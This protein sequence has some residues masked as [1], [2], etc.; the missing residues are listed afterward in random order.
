MGQ[1]QNIFQ[2]YEKKYMLNDGQYMR[3][4]DRLSGRMQPDA[5]G[6]S[7]ICNVYFDNCG[8]EATACLRRIRGFLRN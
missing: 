7:T 1:D 8:C 2:R 6:K 4:T 3:L 5:Y